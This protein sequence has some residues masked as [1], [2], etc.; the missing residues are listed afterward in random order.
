MHYWNGKALHAS[1]EPL[2][3]YYSFFKS[4]FNFFGTRLRILLVFLGVSFLRQELVSFMYNSINYDEG[5]YPFHQVK[6]FVFTQNIS[7]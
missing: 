3:I 1:N 5:N 4:L 7:I 6:C 2:D